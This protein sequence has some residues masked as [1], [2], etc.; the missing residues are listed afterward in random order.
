MLRIMDKYKHTPSVVVT[1]LWNGYEK[2]EPELMEWIKQR[3][4]ANPYIHTSGHADVSSLKRIVKHINPTC[5]VPIHTDQP[6]RYI[7]L[8]PDRNI[9]F[10]RNNQP[11]RL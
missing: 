1:S 4:F 6:E 11:I 9:L 3:G 5:I 2:E 8:Y 10:L 7:E